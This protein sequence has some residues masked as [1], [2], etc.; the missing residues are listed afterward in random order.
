MA[1]F[2]SNNFSRGHLKSIAFNSYRYP[3]YLLKVV[4]PEVYSCDDIRNMLVPKTYGTRNASYVVSS[5]SHFDVSSSKSSVELKDAG[6]TKRN[7][8]GVKTPDRTTD[9]H[10][11]RNNGSEC[12]I[13]D[14]PLS[15]RRDS[16]GNQRIAYNANMNNEKAVYD[17]QVSYNALKTS[18]LFVIDET[19]KG[20]K[21]HITPIDSG[22]MSKSNSSTL[23]GKIAN[24]KQ[25]SRQI[26]DEQDEDCVFHVREES[27]NLIKKTSK[28]RVSEKYGANDIKFVQNCKNCHQSWPLEG[29]EWEKLSETDKSHFIDIIDDETSVLETKLYFDNE[30]GSP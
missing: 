1:C 4:P 19:K 5:H 16:A 11:K 15:R 7:S 10:E 28:Q 22:Y 29:F 3:S 27:Q 26:N 20:K 25:T 23:V 2:R 9:G 30:P 6:S 8:N 14:L 12:K 18:K 21:C 13:G 24:T 17:E